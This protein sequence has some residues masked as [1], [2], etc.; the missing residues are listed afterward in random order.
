MQLFFLHYWDVQTCC[1]LH[2]MGSLFT[3]VHLQ[4]KDS[5]SERESTNSMLCR[6]LI[7]KRSFKKTEQNNTVH[8]QGPI[9]RYK[10]ASKTRHDC[11]TKDTLLTRKSDKI[12]SFTDI[13]IALYFKVARFHAFS[14]MFLTLS[15]CK[16]FFF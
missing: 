4:E 9:P 7:I 8:L 3:H 11:R 1:T 14:H 16:H 13:S 6:A 10:Y 15:D 5:V 12:M 2:F